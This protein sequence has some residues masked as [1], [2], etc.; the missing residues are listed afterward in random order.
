MA[1]QGTAIELPA[2]PW[3]FSA[4]QQTGIWHWL[5]SAGHAAVG[6]AAV[7]MKDVQLNKQSASAEATLIH[8]K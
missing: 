2:V 8:T 4:L 5:P 7:G 3:L 1:S 6:G